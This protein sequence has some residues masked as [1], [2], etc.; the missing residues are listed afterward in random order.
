M[1]LGAL[2]EIHRVY[3]G[4]IMPGRSC[5]CLSAA[6]PLSAAGMFVLIG[7]GQSLTP[8]HAFTVTDSAGVLLARSSEPAWTE[9]TAWRLSEN[10]LVIVGTEDGP[11]EYQLS[12][13][14]DALLLGDGTLVIGNAGAHDLRFYD[15]SGEFIRG[16]G[17]L[18]GGPGEFNQMSDLRMW[19]LSSNGEIAVRDSPLPR[20][21]I[22][23]TTGA[24]L[25]TVTLEPPKEV[26]RPSPIG[27]LHDGG[28]VAIAWES[29][30]TGKPGQITRSA[31]RYLRYGP[32]GQLLGTVARAESA[33]RFTH[34]TGGG[35]HY[36][37]LPLTS[38]PVVAVDSASLLVLREGEPSIERFDPNGHLIGRISWNQE[39]RQVTADLYDRYVAAD[40]ETSSNPRIRQMYES[41]YK[42]SLPLPELV[43]AYRGLYVDEL[44]YIWVERFRLPGE[45]IRIWD[46]L[47]PE[48]EWLGEVTLPGRFWLHRVGGK[49]LVGTQMDSL[50]VERVQVYDLTGRN[51]VH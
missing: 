24:F 29:E 22:F 34:Q 51:E 28:F 31:V 32:T 21:N 23:D 43:P 3:E 15:G 6:V 14:W 2:L 45:T 39:R 20:I 40:L 27:A 7:C 46:V 5:S 44:H 18:G 25:R 26:A 10:P 30:I 12:W 47:S 42:E 48:G 17:R 8:S 49:F 16:A 1:A 35:I 38:E 50:D 19:R 36:P 33:P 13:I 11:E 37:Y 4:V 9:T 41:Y